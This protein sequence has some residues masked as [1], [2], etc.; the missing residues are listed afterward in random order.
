MKSRLVASAALSALVLLGAT[1][2]T[3]ITPQSTE[4]QYSASDGINIPDSDGPLQIR[5]A[6]IIANE[7]GSV[8][9]LVAA[10]VNDTD[11]NEVLTI[12]AEGLAP[13]TVRVGAGDTL[14]LGADAEPLRIEDLGVKPGATVEMYF[15]S[16]DATGATAEVPVLDGTL[17][18]Y[19]DLVPTD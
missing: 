2:C 6:M 19:A 18:Y 9:N 10:I 15:Q 13:L 16:G 8:G 12:E 11:Q 3:F 14:S 4:I 17:P 5:N 1:G 7:D